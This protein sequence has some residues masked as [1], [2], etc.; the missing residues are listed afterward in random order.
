[1]TTGSDPNSP[2][3]KVNRLDVEIGRRARLLR[4]ASHAAPEEL[5][6]TLGV[7]VL[8]YVLFEQGLVRL[9]AASFALLSRLHGT[10]V[11]LLLA[12]DG[13]MKAASEGPGDDEPLRRAVDD[14]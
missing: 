8:D 2:A 13:G 11:Q 1:M 10:T 4:E 7:K 14:N 5:A 3:G 9:S 6:D 12:V